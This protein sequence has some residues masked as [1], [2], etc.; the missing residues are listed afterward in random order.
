M[1]RLETLLADRLGRHATLGTRLSRLLR[2]AFPQ[3]VIV[4]E[5]PVNTR[6][7]WNQRQPNAHLY[8][9]I[10]RNR[11]AYADCLR[12]LSSFA[13]C[14]SRIPRH[15]PDGSR[16]PAW[17]NGWLPALDSMALYTFLARRTAKRYIE[18]GSGNSTKFAR[19]AI[20]D[21][22]LDTRIISID[23]HPRAEIDALC[24][25][26]IRRPVE[27]VPP[28]TFDIL[29]AGDVL[30]IDSSH[31]TL[32]NSDVTMLF[33][34]VL[35]RLKPGVLVQ[36]HDVTLPCDYPAQWN[37][38]HYSEQYLLAAFLLGQGRLLDIVLPCAFVSD[39]PELH[40]MLAPI[41]SAGWMKDAETYGCSFWFRIGS[42]SGLGFSS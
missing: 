16:E 24:D 10:A 21:H 22:R 8:D 11:A 12:A 6:P 33:L 9:A 14:F 32:M 36:V 15:S 7:R 25:E 31:R 1:T 42:S 30:F 18:V 13:E 39:D 4:L 40:G 27:D 29:D 19:R 5:Y 41:W 35:P 38:R 2:K 20:E 26:V 28:A 17:I 23:P 37:D 34:D 3:T